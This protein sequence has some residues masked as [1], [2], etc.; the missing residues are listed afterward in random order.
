M[1]LQFVE[2]KIK[3]YPILEESVRPSIYGDKDQKKYIIE[4]KMEPGSSYAELYM[5]F[6]LTFIFPRVP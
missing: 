4:S 2:V 1:A 6:C 3:L 5:A